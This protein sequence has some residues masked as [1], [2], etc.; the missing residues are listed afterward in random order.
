MRTLVGVIVGLL[1]GV[2]AGHFLWRGHGD[3]HV[4]SAADLA[5]IEKLHQEDIDV[6]LTQDP[7]GLTEIWA[8]DGVRVAPDGAVV[9][10][11]TAI[12]ADNAKFREANPEFKVMK[13]APD[14]EHFSVAMADGWELEVGTL[15]AT[16]KLSGK[17]D[18]VSMNIK[19]L[20]LL[21]RQPDG[22]WEFALVE[23]K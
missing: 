13:Y 9:V 16:F 23:L 7:K 4:A 8:Q 3:G 19:T 18:P 11:K 15:S 20:R 21:Q 5:G 17:D 10:G 1:V 2:G 12:G 14:L 6:T 22:A